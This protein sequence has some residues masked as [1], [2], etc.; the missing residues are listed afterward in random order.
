MNNPL[1]PI[2]SGGSF[3]ATFLDPGLPQNII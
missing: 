1:A 3:M 2:A